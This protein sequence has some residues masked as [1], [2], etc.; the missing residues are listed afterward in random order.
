MPRSIAADAALTANVEPPVVTSSHAARP[1]SGPTV[2]PITASGSMTIPNN[3]TV[4]NMINDNGCQ[5][6]SI[7]QEVR[8][9]MGQLP[10]GQGGGFYSMDPSK[11]HGASFT[12]GGGSGDAPM[13]TTSLGPGPGPAAFVKGASGG[14]D[15]HKKGPPLQSSSSSNSMKGEEHP[16]KGPW[17]SSSSQSGKTVHHP[18]FQDLQGGAGPPNPQFQSKGAGGPY[19]GPPGSSKG[20]NNHPGSSSGPGGPGPYAAE[21]VAHGSSS[22]GPLYNDGQGPSYDNVV[23]NNNYQQQRS[24]P[25]SLSSGGPSGGVDVNVGAP[26]AGPGSY[27]GVQ[28]AGGS[29][30]SAADNRERWGAGPSQRSHAGSW[31]SVNQ[32]PPNINHNNGSCSINY[33]DNYSN[34]S[35]SAQQQHNNAGSATTNADQGPP[36]FSP[37]DNN[38]WDNHN[39]HS[40]Q[41][42]NSSSSSA[43]TRAAHGESTTTNTNST[44]PPQVSEWTRQRLC[45]E[46]EDAYYQRCTTMSLTPSR[47]ELGRLL[48]SVKEA[49]ERKA[50]MNAN[51]NANI[52]SEESGF[53]P[54]D[55]LL[56][57]MNFTPA[58]LL[59]S[60]NSS[61]SSSYH[62]QQQQQ[63]EGQQQPVQPG[64][65]Q[66]ASGSS[67]SN[68]SGTLLSDRL[69]YP[70][71][72]RQQHNNHHRN[73]AHE[74]DSTNHYSSANNNNSMNN[75]WPERDSNRTQQHSQHN[76]ERDNNHTN[77]WGGPQV[78]HDI[79]NTA[80]S[81][82]NNVAS[83]YNYG[84]NPNSDSTNN[85]NSWDLSR[86]Q[87]QQRNNDYS[88]QRFDGNSN[89]SSSNDSANFRDGPGASSTR[90]SQLPRSLHVPRIV[91]N[92]Q[93]YGIRANNNATASQICSLDPGMWREL[94][95]RVLQGGSSLSQVLTF[96]HHIIYFFDIINLLCDSLVI[97][98]SGRGLCFKYYSMRPRIIDFI[99]T[100]SLCGTLIL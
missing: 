34:N 26:M 59:M 41:F 75:Q 22:Q 19:A 24:H 31:G 51:N 60:S 50:M 81:S 44:R 86:D 20:L 46:L 68:H 78:E 79:I 76:V 91:Q 8:N 62:Q 11:E 30:H 6:N 88:Q 67:G 94:I 28:G 54:I 99:K 63:Q 37:G 12:R 52:N 90:S 10:R 25:R 72:G 70:D 98:V 45:E 61:S 96:Y 48:H 55:S 53:N 27:G 69:N 77:S 92:N 85:N 49:I 58:A 33:G 100:L 89:S 57:D 84:Q 71:S 32:V 21:G 56:N 97:L 82:S 74:Y 36:S 3:N 23:P 43:D 38:C 83:N 93:N 14:K 87:Q 95:A 13:R 17:K 65:Q 64:N 2:P 73:G 9:C 7:S 47:V 16:M 80:S 66:Q 29:S 39:N 42:Q 1:P 40:Q 5:Q 35:C 18:S 4:D 15:G